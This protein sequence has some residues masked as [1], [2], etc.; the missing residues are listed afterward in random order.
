MTD[1][2]RLRASRLLAESRSA[3]P[4]D[5]ALRHM[6][7]RRAK[8]LG[9]RAKES[10]A[11]QLDPDFSPAPLPDIIDDPF[12]FGADFAKRRS[13]RLP[14]PP[15]PAKRL[16]RQPAQVDAKPALDRFRVID[17]GDNPNDA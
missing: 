4:M 15:K 2:S 14:D 3:M 17:G 5:Q 13:G 1:E 12:A 6:R 7:K 10:S 9:E 11:Q 8:L 16:G